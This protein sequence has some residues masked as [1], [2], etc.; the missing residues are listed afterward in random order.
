MI[1]PPLGPAPTP[2]SRQPPRSPPTVFPALRAA[3]GG[4]AA[5]RALL[6]GSQ[7]AGL[8][9]PGDAGPLDGDADAGLLVHQ[10]DGGQLLPAVRGAGGAARHR[11][12][13]PGVTVLERLVGSVREQADERLSPAG[14]EQQRNGQW[15]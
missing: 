8:A 9:G 1:A 14:L 15:R 13:L 12:L 3:P 5:D 10:R 2:R 6:S 7:G 11:V 4:R